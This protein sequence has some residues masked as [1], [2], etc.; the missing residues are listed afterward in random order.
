MAEVRASVG[1]TVASAISSRQYTSGAVSAVF[2]SA[3]HEAKAPA[4]AAMP[5][6]QSYAS[7]LPKTATSPRR[8]S[9]WRR[10]GSAA[11][12]SPASAARLALATSPNSGTREELRRF[13]MGAFYTSSAAHVVPV[14]TFTPA[15][16]GQQTLRAA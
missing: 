3:A 9:W 16:V 14:P 1:A 13:S 8:S 4:G 2:A 11:K 15:V 12:T 5:A 7:V 10:I 6:P